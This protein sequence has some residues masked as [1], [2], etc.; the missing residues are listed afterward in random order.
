MPATRTISC[1]Q[2]RSTRATSAAT[3]PTTASTSKS[4][5]DVKDAERLLGGEERDARKPE[6]HSSERDRQRPRS[7]REQHRDDP[8]PQILTAERGGEQ[9]RREG[10]QGGER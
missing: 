2:E 4:C 7:G 1:E 5:D 9:Q 8:P 10:E 3:V 6:A